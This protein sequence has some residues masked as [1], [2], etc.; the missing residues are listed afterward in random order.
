MDGFRQ[1]HFLCG[2]VFWC[3]GWIFAIRA[4]LFRAR[5][6]QK[7]TLN[8][9]YPK[10]G[11]GP[12][13]L[14][15]LT[16]PSPLEG[17]IGLFASLSG[18]ESLDPNCQNC[19]DWLPEVNLW[20]FG[21][22]NG[23]ARLQNC[24]IDFPMSIFMFLI[25]P[26]R[27]PSNIFRILLPPYCGSNMHVDLGTAIWTPTKSILD[28]NPARAIGATPGWRKN[29]PKTKRTPH[30]PNNKNIN[31]NWARTTKQKTTTKTTKWNKQQRNDNRAEIKNNPKQFLN[32][33]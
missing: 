28:K 19:N 8:V 20:L 6:R 27:A 31:Q 13:R 24:K 25:F 29:K 3:S 23:A 32:A 7:L 22:R 15:G 11:L 26:I 30:Y 10:P 4:V 2:G 14:L 18:K 5:K 21:V 33:T 12:L 9:N 1:K 16:K 17:N